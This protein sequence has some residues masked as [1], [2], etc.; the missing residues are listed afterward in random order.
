MGLGARE[1]RRAAKQSQIGRAEGPVH[2]SADDVGPVLLGHGADGELAVAGDVGAAQAG[3]GEAGALVHEVGEAGP[4]GGHDAG[5]AEGAVGEGGAEEDVGD[6]AAAGGG[7][8]DFV[9]EGVDGPGLDVEEADGGIGP[10]LGRIGGEGL[11]GAAVPEE[12]RTLVAAEAEVVVADGAEDLA[13]VPLHAVDAVVELGLERGE[14][15]VRGT[16]G[17]EFLE[18]LEELEDEDALLALGGDASSQSVEANVAGRVGQFRCFQL[19]FLQLVLERA[20]DADG[21]AAGKLLGLQ[22]PGR[23]LFEGLEHAGLA[24][25]DH[26]DAEILHVTVASGSR[27]ITEPLIATVSAEVVEVVGVDACNLVDVLAG[28]FGLEVGPHALADAAR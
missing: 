6:V 9:E 2:P 5:E 13:E 12:G 23:V 19:Q 26:V 1:V 11:V 16:H 22:Q 8:A 3:V 14:V 7:W 24:A 20:E 4:H 18:G 10:E 15:G 28:E 25:G 17:A 21:V 27:L